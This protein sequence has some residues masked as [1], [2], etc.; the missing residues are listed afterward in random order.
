M[1]ALDNVPAYRRH[2]THAVG[3]EHVRLNDPVNVAGALFRQE[4]EPIDHC[5]IDLVAEK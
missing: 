3:T 2:T 4:S 1:S 5:Q